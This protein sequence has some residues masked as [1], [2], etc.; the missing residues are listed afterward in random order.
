MGGVF[1]AHI[2]GRRRKGD[3]EEV[4]MQLFNE[5]GSPFTGGGGGSGLNHKVTTVT[6]E[7][8]L[9]LYTNGVQIL[10]PTEP[11][12]NYETPP[13]ELPFPVSCEVLGVSGGGI[14]YGNQVEFQTL[15]LSWGQLDVVIGR[16]LNSNDTPTGTTLEM[17]FTPP[18]ESRT[19]RS[20][21]FPLL[22]SA[23]GSGDF[24]GASMNDNG[25]YL[26]IQ[27]TGGE[28]T[29]GHPDDKLLVFLTYFM[30]KLS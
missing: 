14:E 19:I 5:D 3:R 12:L 10:E 26:W 30:A 9:G 25:L 7:E 20:A 6:H 28:L 4:R 13:T 17:S 11:N 1:S 23:I 15:A 24:A 22:S 2:F 18:Y 8:I 27:H 29:G 16:S 21:S